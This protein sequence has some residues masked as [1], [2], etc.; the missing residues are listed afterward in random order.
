MRNANLIHLEPFFKETIWGGRLLERE[1]GYQ[2]PDGPVGEAWVVSA[3]PHGESRVVAGPGDGMTLGELWQ[4]QPEL[5]G[6]PKGAMPERF[7]LLIKIIDAA[8]DVSIQV[9]PDDAYAKAHALEDGGKYECWYI[10]EAEPGAT[11]I[12]GQT[13]RDVEELA[14]RIERGEW[15]EALNE[16]P[17]AAG[18]FFAIAPGTVH[19]VKA[20]TMLLEI[21]QPSDITYRLYDYDRVDSTGRTREL[22][23]ARALEV[24]DFSLEPPTQGFKAHEAMARKM[25]PISEEPLL[26]GRHQSG[27]IRLE[28][29]PRFTV[30]LVQAMGAIT[31]PLS[32][33]FT[34]VSVVEGMGS[35][36]G[37]DVRKGSHLIAPASVRALEI[38]GTLRLVLSAPRG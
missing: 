24:V 13:A 38:E 25:G 17:V 20:G 35:V 26:W 8:E 11:I 27:I 2:I 32:A 14:G 6:V 1:F 23:V 4:S 10:L 3:H 9:H 31:H 22:H 36:N 18:D 29:N 37:E 16:I 15:S 12:V 30:D 28:E 7:P 5:F 34:C 19:A 21:Q 33:P